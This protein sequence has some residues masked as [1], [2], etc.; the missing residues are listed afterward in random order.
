VGTLAA[1]ASSP[2]LRWLVRRAAPRANRAAEPVLGAVTAEHRVAGRITAE[3]R[4]P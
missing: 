4:A 1:G 3:V 2:E